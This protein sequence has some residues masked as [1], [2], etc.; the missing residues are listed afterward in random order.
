[1]TDDD[2]GYAC[3]AW[4]YSYSPERTQFEQ[5]GLPPG[6]DGPHKCDLCGAASEQAR[7]HPRTIGM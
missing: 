6:H 5:C 3:S 2:D 7:P 1:M 4:W